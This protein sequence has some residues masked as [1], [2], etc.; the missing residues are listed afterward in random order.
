M[1]IAIVAA[2]VSSCGGVVVGTPSP[3]ASTA[4]EFTTTFAADNGLT[5]TVTLD[6]LANVV[7][8][9]GPGDLP[10]LSEADSTRLTDHGVIV[11]DGPTAD[12]LFVAWTGALCSQRQ[13][14]TLTT[15][16]GGLQLKL[17]APEPAGSA[18]CDLALTAFAI[19]LHKAASVSA[20]KI[21]A[22][23]TK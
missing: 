6:D 11:V 19:V 23:T 8:G 9:I 18:S 16:A 15:E 22:A 21:S 20:A 14:M 17:L 10:R 13:V 2:T 3:L 7:A 1:L 5:I 4:R 12:D